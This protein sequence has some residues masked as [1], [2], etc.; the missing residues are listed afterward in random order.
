MMI[1]LVTGGAIAIMFTNAFDDRL[2][3]TKRILFVI[4]LLAYAIYR[5]FRI[6]QLL[7]ADKRRH[8]EES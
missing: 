5:G 4:M 6:R 7:R 8:A 3:G 2:Y 1:L